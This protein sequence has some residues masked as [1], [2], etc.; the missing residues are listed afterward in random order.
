MDHMM[1]IDIGL[2]RHMYGANERRIT[3]DIP[4]YTKEE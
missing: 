1:L 2:I 3:A 4:D